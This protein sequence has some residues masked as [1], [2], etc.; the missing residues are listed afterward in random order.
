MLRTYVATL[1]IALIGG[2]DVRVARADTTSRQ[3]KCRP[4]VQIPDCTPSQR[5]SAHSDSRDCTRCLVR[6]PFRDACLTQ[7]I[8]S[9]CE[10]AKAAQDSKRKGVYY[11]TPQ[12]SMGPRVNFIRMNALRL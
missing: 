6:V 5:W 9:S 1:V 12:P 4:P 8:D 11:R 10:A 2:L 3:P 7:Q